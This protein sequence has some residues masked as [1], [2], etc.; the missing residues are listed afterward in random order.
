M[1]WCQF[2]NVATFLKH[3]KVPTL[4]FRRVFTF[5]LFQQHPKIKFMNHQPIT[6]HGHYDK[7]CYNYFL[8]II[9]VCIYIY[10]HVPNIRGLVADHF[11]CID[12][13]RGNR[14][15]HPISSTPVLYVCSCYPIFR[16]KWSLNTPRFSPA[17]LSHYN[18]TDG[19]ALPPKF[20]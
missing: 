20:Y 17:L 18:R 11:C 7:L 16:K 2:F 6:L 9:H 5:F 3:F 12:T 4:R 8:Y 10:M 15:S 19:V 14:F 13:N 1:Y